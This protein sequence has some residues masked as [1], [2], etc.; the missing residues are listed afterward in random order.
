MVMNLFSDS[1]DFRF[2]QKKKR[3]VKILFDELLCCKFSKLY[4]NYE[5]FMFL[6]ISYNS[7]NKTINRLEYF[8]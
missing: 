7:R 8:E 6:S 5:I 3:K 2:S 4:S 1:L